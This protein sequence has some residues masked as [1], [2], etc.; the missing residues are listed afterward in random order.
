MFDNGLKYWA[1]VAGCVA[2]L[3]A[4]ATDALAA[5]PSSVVELFT[6]QGCSSCPPAD[7]VLGKLADDP[8]ILALSF[9]VDYWDYLGWKD[10]FANPDYSARQ[11]NY[12]ASRG[13]NSVYTPQ[14][15]IN[16]RV[17]VVGSRE[18]DIRTEVRDLDRGGDGLTV[19]VTAELTGDRLVVTIPDG[20]KLHGADPTV[21]L[22][23]YE[24]RASVPIGRGE[25]AGRTVTYSNIVRR[26]Q[27]IGMWSGAD[28]RI[29][30]PVSD[31]MLGGADGCAVLLQQNEGGHLGPI[32]GAAKVKLPTS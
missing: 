28:M 5:E 29:E 13:D 21:W 15:V 25:N 3:S 18:N 4:G 8:K 7:K 20:P 1:A 17:H 31:L 23:T 9:S 12:A 16:G 19:R 6:S 2:G 30:Y 22:V 10:T 24:S 32:I 11:R 14:A 27:P 26:L